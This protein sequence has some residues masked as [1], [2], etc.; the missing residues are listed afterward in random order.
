MASRRHQLFNL[1]II[2]LP[3]LSLLFIGKR[4]IK[5]Y[6]LASIIIGILEV[7]NHIIGHQRKWWSFMKSQ[8]HLLGMSSLL[9]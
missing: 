4:T 2:I 8:N 3:W 7:I 9:I 6:S 1:I 5:R